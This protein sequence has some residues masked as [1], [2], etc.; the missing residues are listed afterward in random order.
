[1]DARWATAAAILIGF[2]SDPAGAG[3]LIAGDDRFSVPASGF[4]TVEALGVLENDTLD[5]ESAGVTASIVS[6]PQY[7]SLGCATDPSLQICA[8]GSFEYLPDEFFSGTDSF[9]YR[10]TGSGGETAVATVTLEACSTD[11]VTG[12]ISCWQ[13]APFL[14]RLGSLNV[15]RESFEGT[16]WETLRLPDTALSVVSNHI[17]WSS[18][19]PSINPLTTGQSNARSGNW[20]MHDYEHG[21]AADTNPGNCDID[22]PP[23][24]CRPFDGFAGDAGSLQL[25]AVGGYISSVATGSNIAILIDD[26]ELHAIGKLRS[27]AHQFFGLIDTRGFTRFAFRE[28]DGKTGQELPIFG[29]D[30]VFATASPL[31]ANSAPVLDPIGN[32]NV[33]EGSSL[34]LDVTATDADAGDVLAFS[35]TGLPAGASWQDI[36][37][38]QGRL[39][40]VPGYSQAGAYTLQIEVSD[41][42]VPP[43]TDSETFVITVSETNRAP[44]LS[45]IGNQSISA[46][47]LLSLTLSASD[48]DGDAVSFTKNTGAAGSTLVDHGDGTALFEWTPD[49]GQGGNHSVTFTV[50]DDATAPASDSETVTITVS[51]P[52]LVPPVITLL[53]VNP[54]SV[55]Q[56]VV[57]ADPG[58]TAVDDVDG[59][60]SANIQVSGSVN[61]SVPGNYTLVYQVYDQA[62]NPA[63]ASRTVEVIADSTAPVVMAPAPISVAATDAS[64]TQ[65]SDAVISAFL[66]GASAND[67]VDGSLPV[68]HDAPARFPLGVTVVT[69]S[70]VDSAGNTGSA[71]SSVTV[72]DQTAPEIQLN[73]NASMTLNTGDSYT[74]PGASASDNVDGPVPVIISGSVDTGIPGLY[75]IRYD[76]SDSAGNSASVTRSVT[77]QDA[78]APVVMAPAPIS[79]AAT[80]ASGTQ[81]SD[82]VISAFLGG[83]SANDAVDGSLPV[84]HDAPARFPLGVTV[85]TFSAVDS[86]GNTGSAQS[87]VTVSDQTAPEIQLNGNASMTLNT[88]DSYTE[89][90]ASASDNVDGPVPVIIS[91]SVDTGIPGLYQIRYDA[92]DS[93]GNSA[94]VT[95]SVTVQDDKPLAEFQPDQKAEPGSRVTVRVYLRG[96]SRN[97]PA[98][99]HYRVIGLSTGMILLGERIAEVAAGERVMEIVYRIPDELQE[100]GVAFEMLDAGNVLPGNRSRHVVYLAPGNVEPVVSLHLN[101]GGRPVRVISRAGGVVSVEARV[102]DVNPLDSHRFDWSASDGR[103]LLSGQSTEAW[104]MD[105]AALQAGEYKL[106][107]KVTDSGDPELDSEIELVFRVVDSLPVLSADVDS[108][109]DGMDD[110]AEGHGDDDEDGIPDYLDAVAEQDMLPAHPDSRQLMMQTQPGLSLRLGSLPFGI[111]QAFSGVSMAQLT[112]AWAQAGQAGPSPEDTEHEYPDGLYDFEIHGLS[113]AG[114]SALVV[115]PLMTPLDASSVYRKYLPGGWQDFVEDGFNRLSSARQSGGYCPSPGAVAYRTGLNA[116]DDCL[117]L[118]LQDGGPND[119]DGRANAVIRDPGGVARLKSAGGSASGDASTGGGGAFGGLWLLLLLLLRATGWSSVRR[120]RIPR[121]PRHCHETR[122]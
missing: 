35:V 40:W 93:A 64:G 116:G 6:S 49:T 13:E 21:L 101:Q 122:S 107:V 37:S 53:G 42:A 83:A 61:T 65:S 94:S 18:N 31:P 106:A 39:S 110:L 121:S 15:F 8:D 22:N 28:L 79:V 23:D 34:L 16:V 75:Q 62:G 115:I 26:T 95:R 77:V 102:F 29:D 86:A 11:G 38:G 105:P 30:F 99:L 68:S 92:S 100:E 74:E 97:R 59:D 44:V 60:I 50:T 43:K 70:A 114:Q 90:G 81:S 9:Q 56:G 108:D 98:S 72:S 4:L 88:G 104:S 47:Q 25:Q 112:N 7:G 71:Q 66:G 119:A 87:S 55:Q 33:A 45:P 91:G 78:S 84:S 58:A 52:D 2:L 111:G 3:T 80:D 51:V 82:A 10:A 109:D 41:N 103:L 5:G 12:V 67:A 27:P 89:P 17:T 14:D 32:Q 113:W 117:Q 85:V 54:D 120:S 76:A 69:F 46:G 20:A 36:G 96:G 118:E 24:S 1:M 73:G 57:Y 19:F 63:S 48:A